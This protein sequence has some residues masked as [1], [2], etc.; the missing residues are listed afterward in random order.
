MIKQCYYFPVNKPCIICNSKSLKSK[1]KWNK[2]EHFKCLFC[3]TICVFPQPKV[4]SI[5]VNNLEKYESES[6][7]QA[8]FNMQDI[9]MKRAEL[10]ASNIL[11]YKS[12]GKILDVGC[13]YG[14]YLK[15]FNKYGFSVTGIDI[16]RPAINYLKKVFKLKGIVGE[17]ND[18]LFSKKSFDVI[19]MIDSLEHVSNPRKILL[20]SKE[21]MKKE[22][23]IVIQTPNAESFISKLTG[24]NWFW[25]LPS[26][27]L[28]LFSIKSLKMLL[29]QTGFKIIRVSTWDDY[30][31]FI[32]NLLMLIGIKYSGKT[33][34]LHR[35]LVKFKYVL[36]PFS[37]IWNIF[38]LGGEMLIYAQKE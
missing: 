10:C 13:S 37:Y 38:F 9:L 1:Y 32:S 27:H 15:V 24:K 8:Y 36:I 26:Q 3:K 18:Y 23:L 20:K 33:A 17:F 16:S 5:K 14:F 7:L 30:H 22:G 2:F 6:S 31:E 4:N 19:T 34:I 25:L 12:N 28:Y 11:K 29:E 21:I 35:L